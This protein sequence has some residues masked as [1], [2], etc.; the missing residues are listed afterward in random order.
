V[1]LVRVCGHRIKPK[2]VAG[3]EIAQLPNITS[4]FEVSVL[5]PTV[6]EGCASEKFKILCASEHLHHFHP[7]Y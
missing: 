7:P 2:N 4:S 3:L 6:P 5:T 1:F